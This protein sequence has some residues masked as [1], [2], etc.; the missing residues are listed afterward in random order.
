MNKSCIYKDAKNF[1]N[2][3]TVIFDHKI[4]Y[5]DIINGSILLSNDSHNLT[6]YSINK[7][8]KENDYYKVTFSLLSDNL[9]NFT[10]GNFSILLKNSPGWYN[11]S[12]K[13]TIDNTTKD[14]DSSIEFIHSS[15]YKVIINGTTSEK[16]GTIK[17]E[18]KGNITNYTINN[19]K[20]SF[21]D[22]KIEN[23]STVIQGEDNNTK[24]YYIC[25]VLT[26]QSGVTIISFDI[27]GATFKTSP[28][29]FVQNVTED[30]YN[31]NLKFNKMLI[32]IFLILF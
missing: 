29:K 7:V 8:N 28:I 13:F 1:T 3:T 22:I 9:T 17:L 18:F 2:F 16:K 25:D 5:S 6:K 19:M 4:K 20:T 11:T 24:S 30:A 14:L 31:F 23:C 26:D 12:S 21:E 27:C 32:L 10:E 15:S